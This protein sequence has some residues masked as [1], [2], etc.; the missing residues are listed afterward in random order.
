MS[1]ERLTAQFA[2][3]AA[4]KDGWWPDGGGK[5]CPPAALQAARTLVEETQ[6]YWLEAWPLIEGGIQLEKDAD[7][8]NYIE[9]RI[10]APHNRARFDLFTINPACIFSEKED[11]S[12]QELTQALRDFTQYLN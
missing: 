1:K 11:V 7:S 12:L 9:I 4:L 3:I 5:P 10:T 8:G 6:A 2:T